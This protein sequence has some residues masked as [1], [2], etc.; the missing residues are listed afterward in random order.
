MINWECKACSFEQLYKDSEELPR[1]C[2]K[3]DSRWYRIRYCKERVKTDF[4]NIAFPEKERW[5]WAMGCNPEE[6]PNMVKKYPGS[7]YN[8]DGQL[9]IRN[10][11]HKKY[12]MKR[13]G[14]KERD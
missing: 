2:P 10:R 3:C 1:C 4:V 13:R 7:E 8:P 12:E 6:I 14:I 9:K 11:T 5:S